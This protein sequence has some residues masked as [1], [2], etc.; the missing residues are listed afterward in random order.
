MI[1]ESVPA[2]NA[3]CACMVLKSA[4]CVVVQEIT[5]HILA[6]LL[7]ILGQSRR[8]GTTFVRMDFSEIIVSDN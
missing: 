1:I 4:N 5:I 3:P 8:F 2:A 6:S 7:K